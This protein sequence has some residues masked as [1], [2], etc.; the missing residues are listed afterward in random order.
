M[1]IDG[2]RLSTLNSV[3]ILLYA[4]FI[5]FLTIYYL[6]LVDKFEYIYLIGAIGDLS[7]PIGFF[8]SSVSIVRVYSGQNATKQE[9]I[10]TYSV[11]FVGLISTL[12]ILVTFSWLSAL[13]FFFGLH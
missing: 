2:I 4:P 5:F 9:Q 11:G 3:S 7:T 13:F 12:Y 10:M 8:L 6:R 1:K